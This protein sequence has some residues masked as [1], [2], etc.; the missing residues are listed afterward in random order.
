[1]KAVILAGGQGTRLRPLTVSVPKPMTRLLSRPVM[2]YILRLLRLQGITEIA[3]TTA[4]LSSVIES[5]FG[6]GSDYGVRLRYYKEASPLGTAGSVRQCADFLGP[7]DD[8]LVISGDCI[9]DFDLSPAVALHRARQAD[10]TLVLYRHPE[11]LEYGLVVADE[12]GRVE[13]FVEKPSWGQVCTDTVNTGIYILRPEVLTG[14]PENTPYDFSCD[15]F[16]ILLQKKS[17]YAA[18][19]S[20]Y[21]CDIGDCGAFLR[22]AEDM[23]DGRVRAESMGLPP[24]ATP[25]PDFPG[26]TLYAPSYIAPSVK[27]APGAVVGPYAVLCDG[28]SVGSCAAISHSICDGVSVGDA[29]DISGAILGQDTVVGARVRIEDGCVV[30]DGCRIGEDAVLAAYSRIWPE[31]DVPAGARVRESILSGD[32]LHLP[33][34][35]EDGRLYGAL[36]PEDG[37]TL[38]MALTEL[39]PGGMFALGCDSSP[40]SDTLLCAVEAGVRACGGNVI[41]HDAPFDACA[42]FAVRL[43]HA[44]AGAFLVT[45][46]G[47]TL[48][49]LVCADTAPPPLK[50]RRKLEGAML[51]RD[52]KRAELSG[53]G[54]TCSLNGVLALYL[55]HTDDYSCAGA[56]VCVS[57]NTAAASTLRALLKSC[58]A[59]LS[60]GAYVEW[61]PSADGLSLSALDES[62]R[63]LDEAA[64]RAIAAMLSDAPFPDALRRAVFLTSRLAR[65][66][67]T[68]SD[69]AE[70]L[71][72]R[73]TESRDLPVRHARGAVMRELSA[74]LRAHTPSDAGVGYIEPRGVCHARP[75]AD[76]AALR[77]IAE[78][79][80]AETAAE[81]CDF[82]EERIRRADGATD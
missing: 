78:A 22:C 24:F 48:V 52:T 53:I 80:S 47:G 18:A 44:D 5:T 12:H 2:E 23:L 4:Y 14:I 45:D 25:L 42:R 11:P 62:G 59:T 64:T 41:R 21:W 63:T 72:R 26:A 38:G 1:M 34:V 39:A 54:R 50:L 82:L 19:L 71:P 57:G 49:S 9:C 73:V 16:P 7:D 35:G 43:A 67:Q 74:L 69:L 36:R 28:T 68:L 79:D 51:R 40:V 77:V 8:F 76:R 55:A 29:C 56:R 60:N 66:A 75:L 32:R 58:G 65:G 13:R 17:L 70:K 31:Q 81:L 27:I 37:V 33:R 3:V 46:D 15:L 6:D 61:R 10:A 20:G 30:G